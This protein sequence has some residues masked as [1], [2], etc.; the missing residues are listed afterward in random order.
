VDGANAARKFLEREAPQFDN[1]QLQLVWDSIALH[2]TPSIA[3]H[4]EPEV[5]LCT[6]GVTADFLGSRFPGGLITD[7]EY[8]AVVKEL[9]TVDFK[10]SVTRKM[11]GLCVNKPETTYDNFV[12]DFGERFVVG[13]SAKLINSVDMLLRED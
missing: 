5:A 3:Q 6:M 10:A 8:N 2:A 11:C 9:P 7:D 13:Y 1:R 4:K 12:R